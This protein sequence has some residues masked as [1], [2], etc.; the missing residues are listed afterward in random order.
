MRT[1]VYADTVLCAGE[2]SGVTL[3][4]WGSPPRLLS[5]RGASWLLRPEGEP[6]R[7]FAAPGELVPRTPQGVLI[8]QF[9]RPGV[10]A[11]AFIYFSLAEWSLW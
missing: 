9:A 3:V 8:Y 10:K 2:T 5:V 7:S 1:G 6:A 4:R 11:M